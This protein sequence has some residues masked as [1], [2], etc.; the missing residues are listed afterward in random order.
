MSRRASASP[1][2]PGVPRALATTLTVL[3]TTP[4]AALVPG[5]TGAQETPADSVAV[6]AE[7]D[8]YRHAW[9]THDASALGAFF[10]DDADLVMGNQPEA[11][12]RQAVVAWWRGY[13]S[14]QE[15]ERHLLLDVHS[16]RFVTADVAV[17]TV[18]TTTGGP[19]AQGE[20]LPARRFRGTWVLHRM[21]GAWRISAMRGEPT[22]DDQV[23]LNESVAAAEALRPEIRAFVDAY[24]DAFNRHDPAAVTAFFRDD[25]DVIVRNGPVTHGRQ[26]IGEWW[27][28]YFTQ[29][30]PYRAIYIVKDIRMVTS[31]VALVNLVV[32]GA[33]GDPAPR[34][35]RYTR[36]TWLL[37]HDEKGW[38]MTAA[39]VLPSEDDQ[40]LRG[41]GG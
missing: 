24:E 32:T 3:A 38:R 12:G 20:E 16:L 8:A 11:R 1:S 27:T 39:W 5:V 29:D 28:R 25:A 40:I 21:R 36:A 10:A 31:D 34:S 9:D 7:I 13:F 6:S 18:T 41:R 37:A 15:P 22:E 19:D 4:L 2:R 14:N 33:F 17:V 26:A 30:R 23:V 35:V